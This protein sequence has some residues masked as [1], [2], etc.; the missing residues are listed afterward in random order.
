VR[1]KVRITGDEAGAG[2]TITGEADQRLEDDLT[3][4]SDSATF[5]SAQF[6]RQANPHGSSVFGTN[7]GRSAGSVG[8]RARDRA[9]ALESTESGLAITGSA[10]GRSVRVTGDESG[11][12]RNIT[13]NQYLAPAR[14]QAACGFAGG[15]TAPAEQLGRDRADPVTATK[16]AVAQTWAGQRITGMNV[17]HNPRVTGDAPGSCAPLTGSQYQGR[18]TVDGY[19]EPAS[20]DA[21]AARRAHGP[22][23][24]VTGDTPVHDQA[25]TGTAR[26]AGRD[27]TGTPYYRAETGTDVAPA[28]P[29][30]ALD[31]RF[32]VKSPQ[33]VA[34]LRAGRAAPATAEGQPGT[35]SITGSFAVGAGKI[36]GNVEFLARARAAA[37]RDRPPAHARISGEGR[38]EGSRITGDSWADQSNVT[39]TEGAFAAD[40]NPSERGPKAKAFAGAGTF[41]SQAKHEEPKQLVT[42]MFGYFSKSGARVTLSG[43][44]QS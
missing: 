10:L 24:S 19:C 39:G 25:I 22:A 42:G 26:G 7:L 32:S 41:K 35:P 37:K 8:S 40:R 6:Q 34:Q 30:A 1:S 29:V 18:L 38:T 23:S 11:A 12:C 4:R 3:N 9:P 21:A 33:R 14:R 36:T 16:V 17:E 44:A 28:D 27:I 13:G 20:A 15:G 2:V 43:G 31:S 5:T